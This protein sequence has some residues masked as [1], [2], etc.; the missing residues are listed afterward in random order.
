VKRALSLVLIGWGT[1]VYAERPAPPAAYQ[2]LAEQRIEEA[3]GEIESLVKTRPH[4][5]EALFLDGNLQFLRGNY[6]RAAERLGDA[7]GRWRGALAEQAGQLRDLAQATAAAT[8][9]FVEA[10]GDHFI[11][12]Y[13]PGRD[14]LLVPYAQDALEKAYRL[15]ASDF[16]WAPPQPVLVEIYPEVADLAKVSTL[17]VKEIE[18]SGPIALC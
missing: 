9:E 11:I 4:D 8:R 7:A 16:A 10:R 6:T 15:L 5:A 1:V 18:T 3:R 14:A 2:L 12:R 13:A 17:T